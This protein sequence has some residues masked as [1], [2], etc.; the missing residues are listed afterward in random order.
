MTPIVAS[1]GGVS[2]RGYFPGSVG[3]SGFSGFGTK[4]AAPATTQVGGSANLTV[5]WSPDGTVLMT[6]GL[7][8]PQPAQ[9]WAWS[10]GGFGTKYTN[11]TYSSSASSFH[12]TW[13]PN[14]TYIAYAIN[15]DPITA[16]VP[17]S[18]GFGTEFAGPDPVED[19]GGNAIDFSPDGNTLLLGSSD[20]PLTAYAW[21]SGY[22]SRYSA[23]ATLPP[24][25]AEDAKW[26]PDGNNLLAG[27]NG[28]GTSTFMSAWAWSSGFGSRYSNPAT[29]AGIAG[30]TVDWSDDGNYVGFGTSASPR[31]VTY[32]WTSGF[33]TAF[34]APA[35]VVSVLAGYIRWDNPVKNIAVGHNTDASGS[36]ISAYP[37][38]SGGYGSKYAAPAT[39]LANGR[40][41]GWHPTQTN[42]GLS[43]SVTPFI[44]VYAS[45]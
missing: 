28:S 43:H 40:G 34:A 29:I 4:F 41:V 12:A 15:N 22:G 17:W 45:A 42:V 44:S 16:A 36:G 35:T 2:K 14:G 37:W 33:G 26:S 20:E 39:L 7:N 32:P 6:S 27:Y 23:P 11:L 1:F 13:H 19:E 24:Q 38:S 30:D 25:G 5:E 9:A 10:S 31:F 8:G 18:N 21:S 3:V